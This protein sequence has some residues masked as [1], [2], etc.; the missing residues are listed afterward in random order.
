M[1]ISHGIKVFPAQLE[2]QLEHCAETVIILLKVHSHET[3]VLRH[4]CKERSKTHVGQ[5]GKMLVGICL[6]YRLNYGNSHSH[7]SDSR[8]AY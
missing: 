5:H 3:H 2:K 7:I 1:K 8:E 6:G 4:P